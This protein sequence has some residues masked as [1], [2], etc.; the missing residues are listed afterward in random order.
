MK[1]TRDQFEA[2]LAKVIQQRLHDHYGAVYKIQETT[3]NVFLLCLAV[4]SLTAFACAA[5]LWALL[6]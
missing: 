2:E 6:P 5:F 1:P 3:E 4:V